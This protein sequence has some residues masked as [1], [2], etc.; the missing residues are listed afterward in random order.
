MVR[1]L[2]CDGFSPGVKRVCLWVVGRTVEGFSMNLGVME[3]SVRRDDLFCR[4]EVRKRR[5][6]HRAKRLR[7]LLKPTVENTNV[8]GLLGFDYRPSRIA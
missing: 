1:R 4:E 7:R 5:A 6:L 3:L 2:E 8:E